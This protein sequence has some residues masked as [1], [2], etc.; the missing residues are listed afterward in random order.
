LSHIE[1]VGPREKYGSEFYYGSLVARKAD[2]SKFPLCHDICV[3]ITPKHDAV[4]TLDYA[5]GVLRE[6][7]EWAIE[8]FKERP[9]CESYR[10]VVAWSKS[11]REQQGHIVKIW[12]NLAGVREIAGFATPEECSKRFGG[13]WTPLH[14]W[15]KDV[16]TRSA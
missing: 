6:V 15:Q 10:I 11:V 13:G 9:A 3:C 2:G 5:W 8:E 4:S 16:F 7:A 1:L 14:N 12:N